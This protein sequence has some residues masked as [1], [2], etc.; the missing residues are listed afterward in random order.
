VEIPVEIST[1]VGNFNGER[2]EMA[3]ISQ[4]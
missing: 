3:K 1:I 2:V 4:F